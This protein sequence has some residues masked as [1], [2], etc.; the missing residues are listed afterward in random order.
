MFSAEERSS[1]IF[2]RFKKVSSCSLI[3]ITSLVWFLSV[4]VYPYQ[5]L[6]GGVHAG[7]QMRGRGVKPNIKSFVGGG[8][9]H[10][11]PPEESVQLLN[12]STS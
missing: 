12:S 2:N 3:L 1:L 11:Q 5:L 7:V 9:D 8:L 10:R 6:I 4:R